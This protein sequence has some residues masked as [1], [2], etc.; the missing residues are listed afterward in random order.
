M[1]AQAT[2]DYLDLTSG[3]ADAAARAIGAFID[4][5][6]GAPAGTFEN[7]FASFSSQLWVGAIGQLIEALDQPVGFFKGEG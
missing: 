7:G 1:V 5:F 4:T 2:L 3:Q 6:T